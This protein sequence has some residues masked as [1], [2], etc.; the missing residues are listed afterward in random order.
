MR[1]PTARE[2]RRANLVTHR[3]LGYVVS[4][5]VIAYC[6]S[7]IALNHVDLWDPDFVIHKEQVVVPARSSVEALEPAE[8]ERL[9]ALVGESR[10]RI[11]DYPTRTQV[12]IYYESA[13]LHVNLVEGTGLYERVARRPLF[14]QVN[15]LHRNSFKPWRW[16]ADVFALLLAAV[17]ATGLFVLRGANGIGGRGKWLILAG[18]TP[19][20]IALLLHG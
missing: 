2:L 13:T 5:L 9:D 1:W 16:V 8:I 19:P 12:K 20:V 11:V 10:H 3:D 4:S 6:L 17:G 14:H 15:V 18:A 7:G